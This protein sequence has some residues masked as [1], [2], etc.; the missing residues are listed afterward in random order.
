MNLVAI[1]A[2]NEEDTIGKV[3][4]TSLEYVDKIIVC[5]DGSTDK[6]A[7]IAK[8]NGAIVISHKKNLGYVAPLTTLFKKAREENV[9]VMITIDGDGQHDPKQIP[10]LLNIINEKKSDVVIGSRFLN[11]ESNTSAFRKSGIKMITSASNVGTKFKISD[12][13]SGFRAYSKKAIEKIHPT[14]IGTNIGG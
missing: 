4:K 10:I 1:P 7:N 8:Q 9:D 3:V 2:F 6:T 12:S 14:E 5:D 13:Q 11:K